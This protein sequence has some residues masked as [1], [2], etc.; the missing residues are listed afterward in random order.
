MRRT[1]A[2]GLVLGAALVTGCGG[3]AKERAGGTPP[4]RRLHDPALTAPVP[5]VPTGPLA[6]RLLRPAALR[7]GPGGRVL[8]RVGLHT[9]Y[10]SERVFAVAGRRGDWLAVRSPQRADDRPAW[11]PAEDVVLHPEPWTLVAD[12]SDRSLTLRRAGRVRARWTVSVGA[13]QTPTPTGRFGVTDLLTEPAGSAYG[14][15]IV[16]LSGHQTRFRPGWNGGTRLAIHG[17]PREATLGSADTNGCLHLSATAL[18]RL[19]TIVPLGA[20]VTIRA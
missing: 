8:A 5:A 2:A 19:L 15:C 20:T 6:A 10:G 3:Q 14:C 16:A 17:T 9:A 4:V 1:A 7:S 12:L 13:P 18:R 11:V